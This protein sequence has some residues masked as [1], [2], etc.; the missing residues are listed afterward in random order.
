MKWVAL[1]AVGLLI[2]AAVAWDAGERHYRNCIASAKTL[3]DP[4]NAIQREID[5]AGSID[6]HARAVARHIKGCSRL[7]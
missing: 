7:P 4:R 1:V 6:P 2:A 5:R 3:P